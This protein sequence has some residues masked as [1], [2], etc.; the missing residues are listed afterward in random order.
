MNWKVVKSGIHVKSC[1]IQVRTSTGGGSTYKS[2]GW[3]VKCQACCDFCQQSF[4]SVHDAIA[5]MSS[6][7]FT[8]GCC[9][10]AVPAFGHPEVLP[11]HEKARLFFIE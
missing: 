10:S 11:G 6:E 9:G 2:H 3:R 7:I 8:R 1:V 5:R 4:L